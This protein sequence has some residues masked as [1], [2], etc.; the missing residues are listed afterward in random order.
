MA[1]YD[2]NMRGTLGTNKR[3]EK[4]AQPDYSGKCE[5]EGVE[6][7]IS[8]WKQKNRTTGEAFL[9]LSFQ[10]KEQQPAT[11]AQRGAAN[12]PRP[13]SSGFDEMDDDIPF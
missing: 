5:I 10:L 2:N 12:N 4:D 6:Y 8:G 1:Q 9:S 3:K 11:R 13:T 7:W